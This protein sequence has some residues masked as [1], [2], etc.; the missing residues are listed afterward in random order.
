RFREGDGKLWKSQGEVD[1]MVVKRRRGGKAEVIE[2]EQVKTGKNDSASAAAA[3]NR[4]VMAHLLAIDRGQKELAIFERGT[5]QTLK[6]E[7][8]ERLELRPLTRKSA[9][10]Q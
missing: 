8:T 2:M 9:A 10:E 5:G 3:Q 6:R 1:N 4:K 7:L